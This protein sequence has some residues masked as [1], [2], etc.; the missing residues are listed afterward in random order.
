MLKKVYKPRGCN[1]YMIKRD[2]RGQLGSHTVEI[3][4][5]IVLLA[6]LILAI[7]YF[8]SRG[9]NIGENIPGKV[10]V[11]IQGCG[12]VS[13]PELKDSYCN[14]AREIGDNK[15]VTCDYAA[16]S[17]GLSISGSE[18]MV[19]VCNEQESNRK[20]RISAQCSEDLNL[21]VLVNGETCKDWISQTSQITG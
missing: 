1:L 13:T 6:V 16:K 10:E 20:K 19:D 3:I 12:I 8:V 14:Q 11:I 2:K 17:E 18:Y 5:A 15:Y 21:D 7:Y 4:I 9:Q